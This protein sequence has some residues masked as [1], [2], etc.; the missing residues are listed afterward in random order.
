MNGEVASRRRHE[1][2]SLLGV[3]LDLTADDAGL[4]EEFA[5]VFGGR[6]SEA[7]SGAPRVAT[8]VACLERES[9]RPGYGMLQVEGDGLTDPAA[10]L[11]TF[12]SPSIPMR[13]LPSREPGV[14]LIG[15]GDDPEPLFVFFEGA[16]LFRRVPRWR[17]VVS[18]VLFLRMLG[19]RRDALFFHAASLS[20]GGKG[21]LLVGPKGSGKTTLALALACRGHGF[22]G[23][24]TACYLPATGELL[25][26]RRPVG[27]KP[28]PQAAAVAASLARLRPAA[29]EEGLVRIAVEKLLGPSTAAPA[30]LA[31]LVFLRGF[32]SEP[33]L[34][35]VTAGRGELADLQ[36]LASSLVNAPAS[37][38]VFAMVRLV[39][40]ASCYRLTA[41]DADS[42]ARKLE[43]VIFP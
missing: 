39:G 19:L 7:A 24:E 13:P 41:G 10:F 6:E 33:V 26:F 43:E 40:G 15:L 31:A 29:D 25:P 42:T 21:V 16:C 1:I 36:P 8:L 37:Q 4:A 2:L 12:S 27:L 30:R 14:T 5:S 22:L 28:G 18:H 23:D 38:R 11:L 3:D 9:S 20:L 34:E 17:R 32:G 35:P